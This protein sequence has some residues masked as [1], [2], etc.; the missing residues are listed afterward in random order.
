M[1]DEKIISLISS[2]IPHPSSLRVRSFLIVSFLARVDGLR[3]QCLGD[4]V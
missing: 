3:V 4:L 2:L 1:R